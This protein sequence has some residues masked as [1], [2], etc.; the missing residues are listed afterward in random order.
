MSPLAKS[1]VHKIRVFA[2]RILE[3][4]ARHWVSHVHSIEKYCGK[5]KYKHHSQDEARSNMK[6]RAGTDILSQAVKA[7]MMDIQTNSPP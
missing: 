3:S 1:D 2:S 6:W 4:I 5:Q 7:M